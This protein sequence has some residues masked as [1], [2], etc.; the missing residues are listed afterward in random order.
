MKRVLSILLTAV[1]L[2]AA[3]C[4]AP[5]P[6]ESGEEPELLLE[7]EHEAAESAAAPVE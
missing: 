6:A 2:A 3:G 5:E 4:A 1:L 7:P